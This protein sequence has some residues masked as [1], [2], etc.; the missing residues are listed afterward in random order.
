MIASSYKSIKQAA[1]A[2]FTEKKSVFI[3]F[4][5]PIDTEGEAISFIDDIRR[6]HSA[7]THV[8]YAYI[9]KEGNIARFS[10]DGEPKGTAGIPVL[11]ILRKED[12]YGVVCA[13]VRY[14]GG[15]LLGAGG[16]T[17]AYSK[18]ARLALDNAT[19]CKYVKKSKFSFYA[20]YGIFE[21]IKYE[22]LKK[23]IAVLDVI[24]EEKVKFE[25]VTQNEEELRILLDDFSAGKI[26]LCSLGEVFALSE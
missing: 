24:F 3:S 15:I 20:E 13:V 17:R 12:V 6:E 8:V 23:G 5:A 14:F 1:R 21:K 9:N 4:V 18:G 7:A 2:E 11:E 16:L 25:V 22:L 26:S 10:D 19:V